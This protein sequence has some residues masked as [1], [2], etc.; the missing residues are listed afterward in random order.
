MNPQTTECRDCALKH[1]AMAM[2]V[3]K[4]KPFDRDTFVGELTNATI[5]LA[6]FTDKGW[7]EETNNILNGVEGNRAI[8]CDSLRAL[9]ASI[10]KDTPLGEV[11]ETCPYIPNVTER[12]G[13]IISYAV[14]IIAGHGKFADP[15]HRPDLLGSLV[16]LEYTLT[17]AGLTESS[18]A[19]TRYR[20]GLQ[21]RA[22]AVTMDDIAYLRGVK[23]IFINN[24][25]VRAL[26]RI[27]SGRPGE[28]NPDINYGN[29]PTTRLTE[30]K[31]DVVFVGEGDREVVMLL[32]TDN[33]LDYGRVYPSTEGLSWDMLTDKV[34]AW[35]LRTGLVRRASART[36]PLLY[37]TQP[38][39]M[40]GL[41]PMLVPKEAL[42]NA[43]NPAQAITEFYKIPSTTMYKVDSVAP[44]V[45]RKVCCS[46]RR[47][48]EAATLVRWTEDSAQH[49]LEWYTRR[50]QV[51][52]KLP[53]L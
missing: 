3:L 36:L 13:E 53:A 37:S 7:A 42:A 32:L 34:V 19:V 5:H 17:E 21:L 1:I 23:E 22:I 44:V 38:F 9:W 43:T 30:D 14:E 4:A 31:P 18:A 41:A 46:L 40:D 25:N 45:N 27:M 48:L 10:E 50:Q 11:D 47:K 33:L 35:P 12:I 39:N 15:D 24:P 2:S 8:V 52:G 29:M 28:T 6:H 20:R 51:G 49:L 26:E 16:H